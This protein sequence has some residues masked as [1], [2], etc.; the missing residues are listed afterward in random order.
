MI[1][2]GAPPHNIHFSGRHGRRR[3]LRSYAHPPTV[4][5]AYRCAPW[6]GENG[7]HCTAEA[8]KLRGGVPKNTTFI[9]GWV[10]GGVKM[11]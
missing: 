9:S 10:L 11:A 4:V 7:G 8:L 1:F 6:S 2:F 3:V 5:R